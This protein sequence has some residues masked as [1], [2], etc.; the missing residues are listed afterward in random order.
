MGN[1]F[2]LK[3]SKDKST[4]LKG[5]AILCVLFA[6]LIPPFL[7]YPEIYLPINVINLSVSN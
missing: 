4:I 2:N 1:N 3:F 5:I 6:H 7:P